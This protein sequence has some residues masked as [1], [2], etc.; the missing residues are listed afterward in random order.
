MRELFLYVMAAAYIIAGCFHFLR[1]KF[2]KW[3][4]PRW[5]PWPIPVVFISGI[6]EIVLGILLIPFV[7]RNY[8]AWGIIILLILIF[9]AN[10]HMMRNLRRKNSR[11]LSLAILRLP[12]QVVLIWWAWLYT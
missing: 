2:Y 10:V 8:A 1:P 12:L 7:T 5:V 3:M 6:V 11:Y 4:M 9:P